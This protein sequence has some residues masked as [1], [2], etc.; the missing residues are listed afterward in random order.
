M[1]RRDFLKMLGLVPVALTLDVDAPVEEAKKKVDNVPVGIVNSG[2]Q[3]GLVISQD[4]RGYYI[5]YQ[6][7]A[8]YWHDPNLYQVAGEKRRQ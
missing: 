6:S 1:K 3:T 7:S 4:S 2:P 8:S 5:P